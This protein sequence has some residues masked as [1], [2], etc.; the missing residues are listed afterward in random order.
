MCGINGFYN[1]SKVSIPGREDHIKKMNRKIIHRG[2]DDCGSWSDPNENVYFGHQ[3]LSIIDLSKKGHQPMVSHKGTAIVYN[4]EIY[5][6]KN[7]REKLPG[8]SFFSNSDTEVLLYLYEELGEK[9]LE[10]LNGMF[11]F[12]LWDDTK[13]ELFLA[14]DRIGIKPLYYSTIHGIFAFSSEIKSLLLLPWIK[15]ELDEKAFYHFLTFNKLSPPYTMFKNIYKFH[16]G[17]MM[18]VGEK[19]IQ[20]YKPYW[21]LS[22]FDYGSLS[23]DDLEDMVLN[24]LENSVKKRLV[25]DVP[26]GAFMSGGVDSSAIVSFMKKNTSVPIKTYSIG[27]KD[28]PAFDETEYARKIAKQYNTEHFEKIITP[29]DIV[30]FLPRIV[31]IF[32]EP[33]ADATSIPIYF[34]SQLARENGT[35]VILTGD[36]GDELFCG[37]RNWMRYVK[38]YPYYH[39]F[40]RF[41]Q[42]IRKSIANIYGLLDRSSPNYEVFNRIANGQELFWCG[43]GGFKESTK[44][45]F[46][47]ECYIEKIE[48]ENSYEQVLYY[49]KLFDLIPKENTLTSD[50]DW[51]CFSGLM[52]IIPNQYLYRADRLGMAN[53][54]ELRVPFLDH[55]F[56][57]MAM[58]IPGKW[59]TYKGEPK[60]ILKKTLERILPVEILYR[61]KQGFCV[62]LREWASDI[63]ID[64]VDTNLKKFCIET[65][66]FREEG[67][68]KQISQIKKGNVN[69]VSMLWNLY[70]LMSWFKKWIL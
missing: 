43:A 17:Y 13:K 50:I 26:V 56:V 61:K 30:D 46:L 35:I 18:T 27:F 9:C 33:L 69:Y 68:R 39:L 4:G 1:Y 54:V 28:S 42:I 51:L 14:R 29:Q 45:L 48:K 53:S 16:P 38:Y 34:L 70:F 7:L 41:P 55:N 40:I 62:P 5:N 65:G 47:D 2:P 19:G 6:F 22:Y 10:H 31:D 32:D 37:Y 25:S 59:K 66:L 58:S 11:A 52:D 63:M 60:Y 64:Y 57:K 3:R 24:E 21:E 20:V 49:R 23:E 12:A 15:A 36:G 8:Y 44:R 67:I